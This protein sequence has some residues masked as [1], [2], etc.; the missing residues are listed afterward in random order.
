MSEI[1]VL[2]LLILVY[3]ALVGVL[4][5]VVAYLIRVLFIY[6]IKKHWMKKYGKHA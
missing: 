5:G 1:Q 4:F 6:V 2:Q 3:M